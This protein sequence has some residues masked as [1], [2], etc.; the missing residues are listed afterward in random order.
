MSLVDFPSHFS[1]LYISYIDFLPYSYLL[2]LIILCTS[3][4]D[5]TNHLFLSR[6]IARQERRDCHKNP[7]Y[8]VV[9]LE[10]TEIKPWGQMG[11]IC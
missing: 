10:L 8:A 2:S 3:S 7:A 1:L 4:G 5:I 6:S 11:R 9:I